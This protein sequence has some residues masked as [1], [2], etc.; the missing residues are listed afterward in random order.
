M[1]RPFARV[2]TMSTPPFQSQRSRVCPMSIL[3][4]PRSRRFATSL[5]VRCHVVTRAPCFKPRFTPVDGFT[6]RVEERCSRLL[7]AI[8]P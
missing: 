6:A 8:S 1:S 3:K 4:A 7:A 2:S 5:P